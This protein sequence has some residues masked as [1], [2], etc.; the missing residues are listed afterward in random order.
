M[1][2]A[3]V[4]VDAGSAGEPLAQSVARLR[5]ER[6]GLRRA[7][8]SR[9]VIEQAKGVLMARLRLTADEAFARLLAAS[10]RSNVKLTQVAASVLA[11]VSPPPSPG[12]PAPPAPPV[13]GANGDGMIASLGLGRRPVPPDDGPAG[14]PEP[15]SPPGAHTSHLLTVARLHAA[16]SYDEVV[17]ALADTRPTPASVV[18]LLTEPDGALRLVAARGLTPELSS[19]WVRIPPQ[20]ELP[21]TEAVRRAE[22]VWLTDPEIAAKEYPIVEAI[23][24]RGKSLAALPLTVAGRVIGVLGLSWHGAG[25]GGERNRPFLTALGQV[26]GPIA[27]RIA[28]RPGLPGTEE[29]WLW[30]LLDASLGSTAVLRP[31]R[32][33]ERVTDFVFEVLN[34]RAAAETARLGVYDERNLLLSEL[35]AAELFSFYHAVLTDGRPRQL[36]GLVVPGVGP[37]RAGLELVLRAVRLGDRVVASWRERT[38]GELLYEDLVATERV[39][40]AATFRWR[41]AVGRWLYS[42]GLPELLDW[43]S[44]GAP[45]AP[46]TVWRAVAEPHW[47]AVRRAVVAAL[48]GDRPVSVG[49]VTRR[50]RW[51]RATMTGDGE[52][53]LRGTVQDAS[54][55]RSALAR[56]PGLA[57]R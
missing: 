30:P 35:P 17:G 41:P 18:L 23:N 37:G 47:P 34:E 28:D 7:M 3:E 31:V 42:P 51:L 2:T 22:P 12:P 1:G 13:D 52:G 45:P 11:T 57:R 16:E 21:L 33:G 29:A 27:L 9:A 24:G 48:R 39:V 19:Q 44:K 56:Q 6:D 50:G 32:S 46:T 26:C 43:P 25:P 55:Q 8:Q 10:Q 54:A 4:G 15:V 49:L 38:P 20:V 36:D 5:A 40:G 53:G 14:S